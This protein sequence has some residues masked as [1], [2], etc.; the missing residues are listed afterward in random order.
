MWEHQVECMGLCAVV[1][2]W[3]VIMWTQSFQTWPLPSPQS[4]ERS[5]AV[6]CRGLSREIFITARHTHTP[7]HTLQI[8]YSV[9]VADP[10]TN[11]TQ[12]LKLTDLLISDSSYLAKL[13]FPDILLFCIFNYVF[14][15]VCVWYF[16]LRV[17]I[18]K[19]FYFIAAHLD[20]DSLAEEILYLNVTFLVK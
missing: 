15:F 19:A 12:Y 3:E 9:S 16:A 2:Q 14:V 13:A 1:V 5:L 18:L 6:C 11:N 10:Y 20:Q 8:Q 7:T 17:F 4:L